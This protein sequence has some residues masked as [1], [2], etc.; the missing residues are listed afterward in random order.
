[1]PLVEWI[2][3]VILILLPLGNVRIAA[4]APGIPM[5]LSIV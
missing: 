2:R 5:R 4:G 3:P 1:M